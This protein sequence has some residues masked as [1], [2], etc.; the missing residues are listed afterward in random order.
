M[1]TAQQKLEASL[2]EKEDQL[3]I[4]QNL[5][6][7]VD[8]ENSQK[9]ML[10]KELAAATQRMKDLEA[11]AEEQGKA[12]EKLERLV[13]DLNSQLLE[14]REVFEQRQV[15]MRSELEKT[16]AELAAKVRE[17]EDTIGR[18]KKELEENEAKL[19]DLTLSSEKDA[20]TARSLES[21]LTLESERV[22]NL[23]S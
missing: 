6:V 11:E 5:L 8:H 4:S 13:T 12:K 21:K 14:N 7:Q 16:E 19:K 18:L 15:T 9:N 10:K 3:Q 1:E 20:Q 23:E 2:K 22:L 17:G